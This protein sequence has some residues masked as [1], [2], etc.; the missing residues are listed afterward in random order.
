MQILRAGASCR[1]DLSAHELGHN[2]SAV[3]CT[4]T[5]YTMKPYLTCANRFI[6]DTIN[7]ISGYRD[8]KACLSCRAADV[9]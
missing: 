6:T 7:Q 4:C 2:W 9:C 5:G 8:G 1:S 3:H